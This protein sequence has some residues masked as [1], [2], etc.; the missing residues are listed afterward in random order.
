MIVSFQFQ[1]STGHSPELLPKARTILVFCNQTKFKC[2]FLKKTNSLILSKERWTRHFVSI[3][4]DNWNAQKT[5][6]FIYGKLHN[7]FTNWSAARGHCFKSIYLGEGNCSFF[8]NCSL[9]KILATKHIFKEENPENMAVYLCCHHLRSCMSIQ[10][11]VS[12][13][14]TLLFN[15]NLDEV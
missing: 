11:N 6:D 5:V 7:L 10:Q 15:K 9:R 2:K 14:E 4:K 13:Y 1:K 8:L 3:Q 12:D